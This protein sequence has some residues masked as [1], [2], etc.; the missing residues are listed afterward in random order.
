MKTGI[1]YETYKVFLDELLKALKDDF[2]EGVI[3]SFALFGS[4][5]RGEARPD[6]DIDLLIV[7]KPIEFDVWE[8][9]K[10]AF[11]GL[12]KCDESCKLR[13]KGLDPHLNEILLT[14]EQLYEPRLILLDI[15]DH[16]IIIYDN[17]VLKKRFESLG[18]KLKEFGSKKVI[19]CDGTY[20]WDIKPN[21]QFGEVIQ[22]VNNYEN[23][24]RKIYQAKYIYEELVKNYNN[25]YWNI[26][27][28]RAQEIFELYIRAL[29]IMMCVEYPKS[30]DVGSVF[31]RVCNERKLNI[32]S[33]V[34]IRITEVSRDLAKK[35]SPA[36]YMEEIYT[37]E[38][39]EKAKADAEFVMNFAESL[40]KKLRTG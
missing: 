37:Q 18:T 12:S 25:S 33:N 29:L 5:A 32:D 38:E 14:E 6:S 17:G 40:S 3:L 9:Y 10:K 23:A 11:G 39:A 13:T 26:V 34:L 35:R 1:G 2:G 20:Y 21:W 8:R 36:F 15:Y 24:E 22:V 31:A 19:L 28:R 16:G 30:H 4:V 7:H 27:I